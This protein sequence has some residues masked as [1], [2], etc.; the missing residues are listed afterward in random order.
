MNSVDEIWFVVAGADKQDAVS[1]A[2]G[3][4]PESLPVGRVHGKAKTIWFVDQAAGNKTW[5]C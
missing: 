2:F 1:V 5:G 3:D 4:E